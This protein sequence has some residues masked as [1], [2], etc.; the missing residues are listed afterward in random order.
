MGPHRKMGI[1]VGYLSPSII[2]YLD[3]LTGDLLTAR[4]ADCIFNEEHFSALGGEFKYHT[5]CPEINWDALDTQKEDPRTTES[6]L[7]VQRIIHLQNAANNL[8]DSFT[9]SKSVTKSHIPARNVPERIEVPNKTIRL[10]SSEES[11]RST[12]N[13]RKRKRKQRKESSNTVNE[14]QPQVERHQVDLLD[15]L[16]TSTVHSISDDGTLEHPDAIVLGNTEPSI[17]VN[18]NSINYVDSGESYDRKTTIVDIYFA[19]SVAE[20]IQ[21]DP[22]PKSMVECKKRSD[23]NK[24]KE[25]I[26]AEL[27]SLKKRE[28]FSSAIPTPLR[29]FPV[30]FKWVFVRKRN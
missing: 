3:P 21:N 28:V 1:Y 2:K 5:E 30:G 14:T 16:P 15:P 24:W 19:S 25:A 8:P 4:Y 17:G 9:V 18:E 10:P 29:T 20:T 26:E 11:G 13:P 12:E 22:D 27:A 7:Q 6:E 23:W